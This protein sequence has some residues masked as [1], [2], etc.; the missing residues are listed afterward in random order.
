MND[1]TTADLQVELPAGHPLLAALRTV[2]EYRIPGF[3]P[4]LASSPVVDVFSLH[5]LQD[6]GLVRVEREPMGTWDHEGY[7]QYG[8]IWRITQEGLEELVVHG[9]ER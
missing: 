7:E 3:D 9:R 1:I 8:N 4:A 5:D 2:A 6:M